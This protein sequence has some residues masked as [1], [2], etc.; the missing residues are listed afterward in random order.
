MSY[1]KTFIRALTSLMVIGLLTPT[2]SFAEG[3]NSAGN[4]GIQGNIC[5]RAEDITERIEERFKN[6]EEMIND[7][8]ERIEERV[9]K[10]ITLNRC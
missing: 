10:I 4:I 9:N 1:K 7:R 8:R 2:V 5:E 3:A 6:M